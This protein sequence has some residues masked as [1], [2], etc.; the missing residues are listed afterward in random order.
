MIWKI[1]RFIFIFILHLLSALYHQ[2]QNQVY[3]VIV[4]LL[5]FTGA[6]TAYKFDN[7][8]LYYP[9]VFILMGFYFILTLLI[10]LNEKS[11]EK[12]DFLLKKLWTK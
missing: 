5:I 4:C 12:I 6:I 2:K 9:L 10:S 1:K 3:S 8:V 7:M 11:V